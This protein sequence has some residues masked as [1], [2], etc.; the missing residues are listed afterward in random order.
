[1][2][3]FRKISTILP[4]LSV[5]AAIAVAGC[6]NTTA[7]T[8]PGV[9]ILSWIPELTSVYSEEDVDFL[10][11]IQNQGGARAKN[12]VAELTNI[13][14]SEW[15][16]FFQQQTQLGELIPH[17]PVT[18]TPGE[19]KTTQFKNMKAPLLSKGT[20][21]TYEPTIR[22]SYDYTTTA[23]K[24]ITIVDKDE[25]VM[26]Q[27]QGKTLPNKPTTYSL[28]PLVV[29]IIMGN[30]VKTSGTFGASG[31]TYDI[32]PAQ[33]K[34]TNTLWESGG[35][36][37][38]KGFG[39]GAAWSGFGEFDY[40]VEVKVTPP[41]GTN[42]VYSGYGD[43]CSSFQ[44]TVEMFKGKEAE[45]TCELQVTSP[46]TFKSESLMQVELSYRYFIDAVTQLTVQGT[47]EI[48][49]FF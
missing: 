4:L 7:G 23:Q 30:Y 32:F 24:P 9:V 2:S 3:A 46:P 18:Q 20:S 43:D 28:G 25:L 45:V 1:M 27:Q 22:V 29:D 42:F 44:F 8:G 36:L 5:V 13:D 40:P 35:S 33:I 12:V 21:F 14:A 10:L 26:I 38:A 6:T 31:Q 17:D 16:G 34:I 48:S 41:T 11:K 49:G 15:G 37:T 19:T 39:G 47:K